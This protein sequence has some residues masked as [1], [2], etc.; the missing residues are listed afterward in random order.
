M[1]AENQP[2]APERSCPCVTTERPDRDIAVR[3]QR[4][5]LIVHQAEDSTPSEMVYHQDLPEAA[6]VPVRRDRLRKA[7]SQAAQVS[8]GHRNALRHVLIINVKRSRIPRLIEI[9]ITE[10]SP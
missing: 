2:A 4:K 3:R 7:P 9:W 6:A 5:A 1:C 10:V 8:E